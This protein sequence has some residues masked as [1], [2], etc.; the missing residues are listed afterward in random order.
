MT[1]TQ[2]KSIE[3][4]PTRWF[5]RPLT[6][7]RVDGKTYK[8]G[9]KVAVLNCP[10]PG[11]LYVQVYGPDDEDW[12]DSVPSDV[13]IRAAIRKPARNGE[14]LI[15][16]ALPLR[17]QP[18]VLQEYIKGLRTAESPPEPEHPWAEAF[19]ERLRHQERKNGKLAERRP[20]GVKDE[21]LMQLLEQVAKASG[22]RV[23]DEVNALLWEAVNSRLRSKP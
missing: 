7:C 3:G 15:G 14:D 22:R 9:G 10:A 19:H 4:V 2:P 17:N 5:S 8:A 16:Y 1:T 18:T 20:R 12:W 21:E 23:C 6:T 11:W 13:P